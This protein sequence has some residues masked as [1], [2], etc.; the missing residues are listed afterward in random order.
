MLAIWG[1][2]EL[3]CILKYFLC[4]P[5]DGYVSMV[6]VRKECE[7]QALLAIEKVRLGKKSRLAK[8]VSIFLMAAHDGLSD[9]KLCLHYLLASNNIDEVILS[10]SFEK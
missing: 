5:K 3:L 1:S 6:N 9:A 10:S 4:P 7:S 8:E 2:T